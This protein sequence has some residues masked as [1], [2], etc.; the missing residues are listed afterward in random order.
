MRLHNLYYSARALSNDD[1]V[2]FV[3]ALKERVVCPS[4]Y[5]LPTYLSNLSDR[6]RN[7]RFLRYLTKPPAVV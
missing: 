7:K 5:D 1:D 6:E 4:V 2:V 3:A